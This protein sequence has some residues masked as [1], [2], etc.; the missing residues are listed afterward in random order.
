MAGTY[1][2]GETSGAHLNPAIS[3]VLCTYRGFSIRKLPIFV[4]AHV[5]GACIGGIISFSIFGSVNNKGSGVDFTAAGTPSSCLLPPKYPWITAFPAEFVGT[6]ILCISSLAIRGRKNFQPRGGVNCLVS[7]LI[8]VVLSMAFSYGTGAT[9][10][11]A[12][13]IG[14]GLSALFLGCRSQMFENLDWF[15][16]PWCATLAGAIFGGFIYD[17]TVVVNVGLPS[18][19]KKSPPS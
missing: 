10:D 9:M 3:V 8:I 6:A 14:P 17:T 7:G 16:I 1:I 12:Q 5:I 13:S 19:R 4:S 18:A 2:A 15:Y 11:P